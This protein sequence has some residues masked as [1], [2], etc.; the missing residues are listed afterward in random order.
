[1]A[2][3]ARIDGG[4]REENNPRY[5]PDWQHDADHHA[6]VTDKKVA[7]QSVNVLDF[8]V[9]RLEDRYRPSQEARGECLLSFSIQR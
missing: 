8:T 3:N 6:E 2:G 1:M 4:K 9:I 5:E 7:V